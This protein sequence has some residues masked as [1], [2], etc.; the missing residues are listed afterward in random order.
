MP[1]PAA[2]GFHGPYTFALIARTT[3]AAARTALIALLTLAS[4]A[5]VAGCAATPEAASLARKERLETPAI[6]HVVL[7]QL[8][9]PSRTAELVADCDRALPGIESVRGY[10]CG[11][12]MET[13]RSNVIGDYDV[14]I[15]VGFVDATGYRAYL[16]DP[17]HLDLVERWREGWKAVRIFD[18]IS[19][20][21]PE[22]RKAPA[23]EPAPLPAPQAPGASTPAPT[24]ATPEQGARPTAPASSEPTTPT[25]APAPR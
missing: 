11:V 12:P 8:K 17:R 24:A 9:D 21:A 13:G 2:G 19:P 3:S 6:T 5:L 10:A 16:D 22:A 18:V 4:A 15:Y 20:E 1:T 25:P 7:V 14:G 23:V